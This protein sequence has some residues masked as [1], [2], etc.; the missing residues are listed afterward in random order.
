MDS[1]YWIKVVQAATPFFDEDG[2]CRF[3]AWMKDDGYTEGKFSCIDF[4]EDISMRLGKSVLAKYRR[5]LD[6]KTSL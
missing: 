2:K 6:K 1:W 3:V 5:M 4:E